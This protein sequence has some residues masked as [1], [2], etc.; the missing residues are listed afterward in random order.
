MHVVRMGGGTPLERGDLRLLILNLL[1]KRMHGYQ[2]MSEFEDQSKGCYKP[3]TGALYPQLRGLEEEGFVK[4]EEG[5]GKKD[6]VITKKGEEYLER[7]KK[8]ANDAMKRFHNFWN[9]NNLGFLIERI[10][11]I[12]KILMVGTATALESGK[13]EESKKIAESKRI[14]DKAEEDLRAVWK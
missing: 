13:P 12:S 7:N 10:T 14:L 6:Y 8:L 3:S 1:K 2:I 9:D 5:N 11:S 4:C